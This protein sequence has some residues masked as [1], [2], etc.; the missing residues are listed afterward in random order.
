MELKNMKN[1]GLP[2]DL[3]NYARAA[4]WRKSRAFVISFV[5][6]ALALIFFGELVLSSKYPEVKPIIYTFILA[7]PFVFTKFPFCVIDSTY[8]GIVEDIEVKMT[9]E[10]RPAA[11]SYKGY[12]I[13]DKGTVYLKIRTPDGDLIK[14]KVYGGIAS[15]QKYIDKFH[16]DDEVFHLYGTETV[17]VLRG[18]RYTHVQCPVC[19]E[20]NDKE[21]ELCEECGHTLV[22]DLAFAWEGAAVPQKK[23]QKERFDRPVTIRD[24]Y[25]EEKKRVYDDFVEGRKKPQRAEEKKA[26]DT[27]KEMSFAQSAPAQPASYAEAR[28]NAI[29][30]RK[31]RETQEERQRAQERE[32]YADYDAEAI[33]RAKDA[34]EKKDKHSFFWEFFSYFGTAVL[35]SYASS[36]IILPLLGSTFLLAETNF[37]VETLLFSIILFARYFSFGKNEFVHKRVSRSKIFL[38]AIPVWAIFA[39]AYIVFHGST[40]FVPDKM[41][42]NHLSGDG[43]YSLALM[44]C[45]LG[46]RYIGEQPIR[47]DAMHGWI[48]P[49]APL[50]QYFPLAWIISFVLNSVYYTWLMWT[51][52]KFGIS[53]KDIERRDVIE[54]TDVSE[55]IYEKRRFAKC[56]I[57]FINYYPIYSWSYEYWVNPIPERKQKYFWR[58]VLL[59]AAGMTAIEILRFLF[60]QMCKIAWLNGVVFYLSLH[61]VGCV[62]SLVAYFD[63]KRHEKLMARYKD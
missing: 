39:L 56:F 37:F 53:E 4:L 30:A 38:S 28:K 26:A 59:M 62:I 54:K 43:I 14:R 45:G 3:K 31:M 46:R 34:E 9:K 27:A 23:A 8:C 1:N 15:L 22:C 35:I 49:G 47:F 40:V 44:F 63:D 18:E 58:G 12:R 36:Y 57:P 51:A 32:N 50:P 10:A 20:V 21:N 25:V 13:F 17:V 42:G 2:K 48:R 52:Y 11:Y 60:Y 19:G 29:Q 41:Y 33:K 5:L 24:D 61:L 16:K 6:T 55:K 7:L